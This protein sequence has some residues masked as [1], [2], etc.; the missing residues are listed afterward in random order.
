MVPQWGHKYPSP[1]SDP[2]RM[3]ADVA[4]TATTTAKIG[5]R[6][7]RRTK[8]FVLQRAANKMPASVTPTVK[9]IWKGT[10]PEMNASSIAGNIVFCV[11]SMLMLKGSESFTSCPAELK[12]AL[13]WHNRCIRG[14]IRGTTT[15]MK[16]KTMIVKRNAQEHDTKPNA[17]Q[18]TLDAE[19][20]PCFTLAILY[21]MMAESIAQ[22]IPTPHM[23]DV[24]R[25]V[26]LLAVAR[27]VSFRTSSIMSVF[28][29]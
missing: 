6:C 24:A 25:L 9:S 16:K 19:G 13:L 12:D 2:E 26:F 20:D 22:S 21:E 8:D 4:Q 1:T 27:L 29:T 28:N 17:A 3:T 5:L 23:T 15:K 18:H 10:L 7:K 14:V 11:S